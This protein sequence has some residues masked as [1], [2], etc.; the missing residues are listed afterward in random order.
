M[1]FENEN[2]IKASAATLK[3]LRKKCKLFFQDPYSSLNPRLTIGEAI[4][5]PLLVHKILPTKQQR[6]EKVMELLQ[7]S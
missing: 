6:K 4:E 7:K 2:L 3:S 5:E 1:F